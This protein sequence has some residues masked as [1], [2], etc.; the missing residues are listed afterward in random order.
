M[1]KKL[2]VGNLAYSV[3]DED[4]QQMFAPHGNVCS[5]SVAMESDSGG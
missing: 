5:A 4:L 3:R 2:Y 1:A